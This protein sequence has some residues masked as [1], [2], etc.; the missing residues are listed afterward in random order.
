MKQKK[1]RYCKTLFTPTMPMQIVCGIE[2]AKAIAKKKREKVEKANDRQRKEELK[3]LQYWLKRTEKAVNAFV[4]ERDREQPC[5]SCGTN[6]AAEWHAGHWKSVGANSALRFD[7]ANIHR[8]CDQ[9]N[10]FKG[11]N[12]NE[13]EIRLPARIGQAEVD[14]LK[15]AP[16]LRKWTREECQAIENEFKAKLKE[17]RERET[18]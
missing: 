5:I 9:C 7:P 2:C 3:P 12:A 17:L 14:R 10:V 8:Q 4:R 16:R 13:Y 1:C 6:D 11:G 18:A 15:H